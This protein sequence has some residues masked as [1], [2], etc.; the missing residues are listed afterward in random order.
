MTVTVRD[1]AYSEV[2]DDIAIKGDITLSDVDVQHTVVALGQDSIIT[3]TMAFTLPRNPGEKAVMHAKTAKIGT[4]AASIAES[5]TETSSVSCSISEVKNEFKYTG[6]LGVKDVTLKGLAGAVKTNNLSV[7]DVGFTP[8]M[9]VLVT[10]DTQP[11][12]DG[13][14]KGDKKIARFQ[15]PIAQTLGFVT[16]HVPIYFTYVTP[17]FNLGIGAGFEVP[18][19]AG[20]FDIRG[21]IQTP[22]STVTTPTGAFEAKLDHTFVGLKTGAEIKVTA[23]PSPLLSTVPWLLG[24]QDSVLAVGAFATA[25]EEGS[26]SVKTDSLKEKPCL[27]WSFGPRAKAIVET[28]LLGDPIQFLTGEYADTPS[29]LDAIPQL[30]VEG[31]SGCDEGPKGFWQGTA[32]IEKCDVPIGVKGGCNFL[33]YNINVNDPV[34]MAFRTGSE[35][36][37]LRLD[38]IF[39][40][41]GATVPI[42]ET[43]GSA[44]GISRSSSPPYS[45]QVPSSTVFTVTEV[46]D[47]EMRGTFKSTFDLALY[48]GQSGSGTGTGSW[49]ARKRATTFPKC[50]PPQRAEGVRTDGTPAGGVTLPFFCSSYQPDQDLWLC[51]YIPLSAP[52]RAN[53]WVL[54]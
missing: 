44:F 30:R 40:C 52:G 28:K 42:S 24:A 2:L 19:K 12:T 54:P 3:S 17:K 15:L 26:L 1:A 14:F 20:K 53:E 46:T 35:N 29:L 36:L 18:Y 39:G 51:N 37:N 5:G 23:L 16:I 22:L 6:T 32:Y 41:N 21:T 45:N 10:V 25:G 49:I 11:S 47:N 8:Y 7:V 31:S 34:D 33:S 13:L 4:C 38:Q 9:N 27:R 50:L 43:T 48:N